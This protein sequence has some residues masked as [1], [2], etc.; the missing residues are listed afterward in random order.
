MQ[1]EYKVHRKTKDKYFVAHLDD[2]CIAGVIVKENGVQ[3]LYVGVGVH[4]EE[5]SEYFRRNA[6]KP[7]AVYNYFDNI[8]S[9]TLRGF[10]RMS[11]DDFDTMLAT[12]TKKFK[13]KHG[14]SQVIVDRNRVI[15]ITSE[16]IY[17]SDINPEAPALS[18]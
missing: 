16:D 11:T 10:A 8:L 9:E 1:I 2:A 18:M 7:F 5:R 17:I 3:N 14:V 6:G 13:R 15:T 12:V 4:S